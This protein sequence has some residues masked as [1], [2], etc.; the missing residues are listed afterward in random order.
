MFYLVREVGKF[1]HVLVEK[2]VTEKVGHLHLVYHFT[3]PLKEQNS[4]PT[5]NLSWYFLK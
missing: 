1:G 3:V 2:K 5:N 4:L